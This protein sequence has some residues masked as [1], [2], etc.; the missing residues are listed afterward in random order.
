MKRSILIL[1]GLFFLSSFSSVLAQ[2]DFYDVNTIQEIK[3]TFDQDNWRYVLDSL[4]FNG[5]GLLLG[6]VEI[7]GQKFN[8][9]GVR[10]RGSRSFQPG[11]KRN[12]LYIKLN[13]IDKEQNYQGQQSVKL[14]S[15]LRDPSMVRE[16]LGYEIARQY[17]P[18][19]RANY[20][21]VIVN[22]EYYGLFVNVEPIDDAF[23]AN[24][25]GESGGTFVQCA[26][27]LVEEEPPGCKSDVFGS[28]QYDNSAK[29]YLHN[30]VLLS[31]SGWDDLIELT[32]VLNQEPGAVSRVL[33]VDRTLWMLAYNNLLVNLSSYTGRYSE[34][35]YLYKDGQGQFVP[36]LYDL[37][38][39]FGSYKNTGV[40]SDLKLK[41]LQEMDP[42]LHLNNPDK[43]LISRLL[44]N[45]EYKK[46]YL[47]HMR[48]MMN[49]F[50]RHG[51]Y[52][53][54]AK[55]LQG[56]IRK[57]FE[58]DAN[59][60]YSME[61]FDAS[62][63]ETI[64]KRSRIPGLKELMGPRTAFLKENALLSVV[65]PE[66]SDV[67]VTRRERFSSEKVTDFK[68]QARI[69]KFPKNVVLFYRFDHSMPFDKVEMRDDGQHNDGEA[70]DGIFGAVVK[71]RDGSTS[72]EYFIYAENAKAVAYDPPRYMFEQYT[73]SLEDL[74]N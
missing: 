32:Y 54:R 7:N 3:I 10:Y 6:S 67:S 45:E 29:C 42:L 39:C 53:E 13:F 4:R 24:H 9:I 35:Y 59:R 73:A 52:A 72:V 47:A 27:N 16:V 2:D 40:G 26:P 20:T 5:E 33:D 37:N 15:A 44:S 70:E 61:D 65:P 66:V 43:P 41:E 62:L 49:D 51:E 60:Y 63:T 50:F 48:T 18:A 57:A 28:L 17:M 34:N 30:F 21:R 25:F 23:L 69:D 31:E 71:P 38:L 68:I 14:S 56:L 74:N 8:D 58:E 36:I 46:A 55:E 22:G 1:S 19:P 12:S 64:G 11:N